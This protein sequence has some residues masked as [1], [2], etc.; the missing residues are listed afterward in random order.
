LVTGSNGNDPSSAGNASIVDGVGWPW[1]CQARCTPL[2]QPWCDAFNP[3]N[4]TLPKD[5]LPKPQGQG[6]PRLINIFNS[7]HVTLAGFTAQNSPQWTVHVQ[8]SQ[9]VLI[10]NMTVLSP[11]AV[12][13][14]DGVDPESSE[15]VLVTDTHIDVGDDGV[16][17]KSYNISGADGGTVMIP[18]RRIAMRRLVIRSR[19]WCIGSGTFGGVSEVLFEDSVVGDSDVPVPWA[20]K[21]KSHQCVAPPPGFA[22]RGV[23]PL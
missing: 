19:N 5:Q 12:G 8:N 14:T 23:R 2:H 10:A 16:S 1:W 3:T 7:T 13:N 9:D 4:A 17:I 21:F 18:C 22:V 11:R 20:F 15:D 6:R